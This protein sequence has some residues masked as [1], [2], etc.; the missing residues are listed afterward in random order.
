MG[1]RSTVGTD[2]L[3]PLNH[4][5]WF[6]CSDRGSKLKQTWVGKIKCFYLVCNP[7]GWITVVDILPSD[8]PLWDKSGRGIR[9]RQHCLVAL[10]CS[11][12]PST[13][14][15]PSIMAASQSIAAPSRGFAVREWRCSAFIDPSLCQ[16]Q[17]Q[18]GCCLT[19]RLISSATGDHGEE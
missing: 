8:A 5:P 1:K 14:P 13:L 9:M 18:T 17:G 2:S 12:I 15:V 4:W 6:L 19:T 3:S 10:S 7:E 11:T 16:S